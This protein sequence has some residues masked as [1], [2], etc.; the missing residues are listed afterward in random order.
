MAF[1][2]DAG[3][4]YN[5]APLLGNPSVVYMIYYPAGVNITLQG[6]ESCTSF[7][8]YHSSW[9]SPTGGTDG[10]LVYAVLPNCVNQGATVDSL[11]VAS[12]HELIEACTDPNYNLPAYYVSNPTEAQAY[13]FP[14]VANLCVGT[15]ITEDGGFVAQ[16]IYSNTLAADGGSS[17]CVPVPPGDLY[18]NTSPVGPQGSD[19]VYLPRSAQ[20]QTATFTVTGW[21]DEPIAGGWN[22]YAIQ[23][24]GTFSPSTYGFPGGNPEAAFNN[25]VVN[26]VT[27]T[28]PGNVPVNDAGY[29][30]FVTIELLSSQDPEF[31]TYNAWPL[32][33]VLE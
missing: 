13:D 26:T 16:R 3:L 32:T 12:S 20:S 21:S 33:V 1:A 25:G 31:A 11:W 19:V 28:I 24:N 9:P 6:A 4:T 2:L 22:V 23:S 30:D 8:G 15:S 10:V 7:G 5:G 29:T 18:F 27:V 14:E 17:P